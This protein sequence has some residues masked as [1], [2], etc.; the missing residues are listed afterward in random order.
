MGIWLILWPICWIVNFTFYLIDLNCLSLGEFF[1]LCSGGEGPEVGWEVSVLFVGWGG[2]RLS[3]DE[4]SR[5]FET[6]SAILFA[7]GTFNRL[8]D[9]SIHQLVAN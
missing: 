1:E 2:V 3:N 9:V 6:T 8:P 7:L 4:L 5:C